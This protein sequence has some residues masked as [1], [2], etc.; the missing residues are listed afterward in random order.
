MDNKLRI[1]VD[2]TLPPG[3][4]ASQALHAAREF[5]D[6]HPEIEEEWHTAS[7]NIVILQAQDEH[8]LYELMEK[9]DERKVRN[10]FFIDSDLGEQWTAIA[11]EPCKEARRLTSNL[12]LAFKGL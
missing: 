4:Q 12:P 2:G 11:L 9:A 8:H 1:V 5:A 7:N 3:L 10:S 6:D